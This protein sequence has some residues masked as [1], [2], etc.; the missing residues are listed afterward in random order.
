[1]NRLAMQ[2]Y[3]KTVTVAGGESTPASGGETMSYVLKDTVNLDTFDVVDAVS[4]ATWSAARNKVTFDKLTGVTTASGYDYAFVYWE[5]V[6]RDGNPAGTDPFK[7]KI[8]GLRL[9]KTDGSWLSASDQ[10]AGIYSSAE[11]T[12]PLIS[13][14]SPLLNP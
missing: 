4:S 13:V 3:S 1:M 2:E 10:N 6:N 12:A 5:D 11:S 7:V 14:V 9:K 8:T